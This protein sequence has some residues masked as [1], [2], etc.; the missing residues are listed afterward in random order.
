[1]ND[2]KITLD[3]DP[4]TL[5]EYSVQVLQALDTV[6]GRLEELYLEQAQLRN[7]ILDVDSEM[8]GYEDDE[9]WGMRREA[10]AGKK[11]DDPLTKRSNDE[12]RS[13]VI[14]RRLSDNAGYEHLKRQ[15]AVLEQRSN[16]VAGWISAN[17]RRLQALRSSAELLRELL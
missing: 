5:R 12:Y 4:R 8:R 3:M 14:A 11:F 1:M 7:A 17:Y 9:Y 16:E 13:K 15:R 2:F 6:S 10:A